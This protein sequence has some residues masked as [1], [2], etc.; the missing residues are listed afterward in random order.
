MIF[1]LW[2]PVFLAYYPGLFAYDVMSQIP[3]AIGSYST[4]HPL[5]HTLY[6]QFFYNLIG[7]KLLNNY[8]SGIAFASLVQMFLFS[9]MISYTHLFFRRIGVWRWVRY[10]LIG[11][12]AILPFFSMLAISMTKDVFFSGF[13][14]LF[15]TN[16]CYWEKDE[17]YY[18]RMLTVI[19][20]IISICGVI[21]FRN[22]GI[23]G[24][25]IVTLGIGCSLI[26]REKRSKQFLYT[27]VG[28]LIG[29]LINC[30]LK[31]G[32]Q[33][34]KGSL[35]EALS[36]PYQQISCVYNRN[37][38]ELAED[39]VKQIRDFIPNVEQYNP[40]LSDPVKANAYG[41][42]DL[43]G[44]LSLYMKLGLKYP[45]SYI[46]AYTQHNLG[47]LYILDIS[48]SRIYG[49]TLEERQGYLLTDT[50]QGFD[51]EHK[52]FVPILEKVYERLYTTNKYQDLLI[53]DLLCS[54]GF[55]F[56]G[57]VL[58]MFYCAD[59]RCRKLFYPALFVGTYMLTLLDGP[60]VLIRYALPYI[61]CFP[62]M[63][64][65]MLE[66]ENGCGNPN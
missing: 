39:E 3:Q 37:Y 46:R 43:K 45:A 41:A 12:T 2:I 19:F 65:F 28:L 31:V 24:V 62:V 49:Y 61:V 23:Y 54:P 52:S 16:L 40:S 36:L 7:G 47:Y 42:D 14:A 51:I 1:L 60:C 5:I 55:Y 17:N 4:H 56:W 6:L 38:D 32:L 15:V 20:Y 26:L 21:L 22:N 59:L 10:M 27:L 33:A 13:V 66:G 9:M 11:L 53:L 58:I 50:K 8:N 35:N 29:I 44:F 30:G 64:C 18:G 34:Q 57:I 25:V 48:S 63:L